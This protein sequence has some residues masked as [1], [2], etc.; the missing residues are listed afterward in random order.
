MPQGVGKRGGDCRRCGEPTVQVGASGATVG[1]WCQACDLVH[2]LAYHDVFV[3][4]HSAR[5]WK[6]G[7]DA[8]DDAHPGVRRPDR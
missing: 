8:H 4:E 6:P 5:P 1:V 7:E 3:G 2:L